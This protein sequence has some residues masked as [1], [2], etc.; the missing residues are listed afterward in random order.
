[1]K[2]KLLFFTLSITGLVIISGCTG[3]Q[4]PPDLT[5]QAGDEAIEPALGP[6]TWDTTDEGGSGNISSATAESPPVLVS[7]TDP[8]NVTADTPIELEFEEKPD[9]YSIRIWDQ[10][11]TVVSESDQVDLSGEGHVI[12][13]VLAEWEEGTASYSFTLY[14][15]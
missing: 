1:M 11:E 3:I 4:T 8:T 6:Y 5:I 10:D 12:Y 2:A 15:E 13:E 14:I 7:S 9:N